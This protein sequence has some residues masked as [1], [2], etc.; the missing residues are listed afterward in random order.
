M[1]STPG[2]STARPVGPGNSGSGPVF[3]PVIRHCNT[4]RSPRTMISS[5]ANATSGNASASDSTY[6]AKSS[7]AIGSGSIGSTYVPPGARHRTVAEPSCTF[8]AATYARIASSG[9]PPRG[10]PSCCLESLI[11]TPPL[12]LSRKPP[13]MM[14]LPAPTV[15]PLVGVRHTHDVLR[16]H[17]PDRSPGSVRHQSG[18]GD[19]G[20]APPTRGAPTAHTAPGPDRLRPDRR[21][22]PTTAQAS[23]LGLIT[24]PMILCSQRVGGD[25][26]VHPGATSQTARA[27]HHAGERCFLA[28]SSEPFPGP[29]TSAGSPSRSRRSKEAWDGTGDAVDARLKRLGEDDDPHDDPAGPTGS[30]ADTRASQ[31]RT[32]RQLLSHHLRK[33]PPRWTTSSASVPRGSYSREGVRRGSHSDSHSATSKIG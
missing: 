18:D 16:A 28:S 11:D 7:P 33:A 31:Q 9:D 29:T 21:T 25:D 30:T 1:M 2:T 5:G 13:L 12:I 27:P 22:H 19:P 26:H 6:L 32:R 8:H 10:V 14:A 3:V 20:P 23:T 4:A 24:T 17:G 15:E